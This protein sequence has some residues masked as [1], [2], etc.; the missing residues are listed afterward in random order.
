MTRITYSR[1]TAKAAI[2]SLQRCGESQRELI[3]KLNGVINETQAAYQGHISEKFYEKL[4]N[5]IRDLE[6]VANFLESMKEREQQLI[7]NTEEYMRS[8][9]NY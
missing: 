9:Q 4:N 7:S 1:E 2:D 6:N 3:R 5:H 8:I